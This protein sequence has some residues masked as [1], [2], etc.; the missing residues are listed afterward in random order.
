MSNLS[1]QEV[2]AGISRKAMATIRNGH[3]AHRNGHKSSSVATNVAIPISP[4]PPV[5]GRATV[6]E[7]TPVIDQWN[8]NIDLLNIN[9]WTFHLRETLHIGTAVHA[10]EIQFT[11]PE[12]GTLM[13]RIE[14]V[15]E[16]TP[17]R[18]EE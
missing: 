12:L 18:E 11:R 8:R 14:R 15:L 5:A 7:K 16:E 3:G 1:Q 17:E 10:T 2:T 13:R 6:P 4:P 9:G